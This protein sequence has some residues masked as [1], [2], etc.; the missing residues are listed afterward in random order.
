MNSR[1]FLIPSVSSGSPR[2]SLAR[3]ASEGCV[4]G[5]RHSDATDGK[6][7]VAGVRG[8]SVG[9]WRS[10]G[11][12][13]SA[14]ERAVR[15]PVRV[16]FRR[17]KATVVLLDGEDLQLLAEALGRLS[18]RG[19][20]LFGKAHGEEQ[21]LPSTQGYSTAQS[22]PQLNALTSSSFSPLQGEGRGFVSLSAH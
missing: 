1:R 5:S 13:R 17:G 19:Y 18:A 9:G 12:S 3:G 20:E 2:K 4:D 6:V 10:R 15:G 22:F 21:A 14:F 16:N 7:V 11:I 8:G